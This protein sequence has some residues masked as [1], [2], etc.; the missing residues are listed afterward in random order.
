MQSLRDGPLPIAPSTTRA[1][2][3][4][5]STIK[6]IGYGKLSRAPSACPRSYLL[7]Q[8]RGMLELRRKKAAF[9]DIESIY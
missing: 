9:I 2:R 8:A 6:K 7:L 3:I 1:G 4:R 5:A